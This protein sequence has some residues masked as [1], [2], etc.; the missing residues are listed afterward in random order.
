MTQQ[1][2][3]TP[4][5]L[6]I[7][8][9]KILSSTGYPS[10]G[11]ATEDPWDSVLTALEFRSLSLDVVAGMDAAASP[12]VSNP[13]VTQSLKNLRLTNRGFI[14]I[15]T[16]GSDADFEG[17]THS[18]F[19]A[20]IASL[21]PE[22]GII[23]V[24]EG[25]YVFD[26]TVFLPKDV[27]IIGIHPLSVTIQGTG[28][29]P[30]FDLGENS[31]VELVTV[32]N[33]TAITNPVLNLTGM[34]S[35]IRGSRI[36]SY[37]LLGVKLVG[38]KACV[39][40]CLLD[41]DSSGIWLQGVYQLVE[42]CSFSGTL[43]DGVLRFENSMCSAL[44]NFIRD[45]V[46]GPSYLINSPSN[47]NN[48]LVANHLGTS[49][50]VSAAVDNGTRSVRYANTP[51]M[52]NANSNNFLLSLQLYTG[53]PTLASTEMVL[54]NHVAH[55]T[56]VDKDATAIL[57]S[58]DYYTQKIYERRFWFLTSE[59]P[60]FD[61]LGVPTSGVCSWDGTTLNWPAFALRA[62]TPTNLSWTV[63]ASSA[64]IGIGKALT[65]TIDPTTSGVVVPIVQDLSLVLEN[66]SDVN[67]QVIAFCPASGVLIW[68][69]GYR[70]LT[71]LTSFDIDGIPLPITRY[72]GISTDPRN[73][74]AMP[75]TSFA[76][77][78]DVT[79][80]LSSQS[81][82]LHSLY[83]RSNLFE[84][85]D[86]SINTFPKAGYLLD[87][88]DNLLEEPS[89]LVQVKG[90]TYALFPHYGLYRWYRSSGGGAGV[91][92][93][94]VSNPTGTGPYAAMSLIG[95]SSIAL[96]TCAGAISI[97]NTDSLTWS[98]VTPTTALSLPLPDVRPAGYD[99]AGQ[100]DF[101]FQTPHY[102]LFTLID[103]RSLLYF[104]SLNRLVES[105]RIFT[106]TP[107]G[108]S[109][110]GR[111]LKDSGFNVARNHWID[112]VDNGVGSTLEGLPLFLSESSAI[113]VPPEVFSGSI[114]SIKWDTLTH[115]SFSFDPHSK[116]FLC[117]AT[118]GTKFYILGGGLGSTKL[119]SVVGIGTTLPLPSEEIILSGDEL[120]I[121]ADTEYIIPAITYAPPSGT[122]VEF[123]DFIPHGWLTHVGCQEV[124]VFGT[125]ASTKAF[126]V[127][128]GK[129]LFGSLGSP[130]FS[131]TRMVLGGD[132]SNTGAIGV[133]D[134][135]NNQGNGDIHI[136]ASD[137]ARSNRPTWWTY[138]RATATWSSTT[139]SDVGGDVTL[140][141][142][143]AN[144]FAYDASVDR[145]AGYGV[146]Y[147]FIQFLVRDAS[148]SGRPTMFSYDRSTYY[149]VRLSE[150]AGADKLVANADTTSTS[151]FY[152]GAY[153]NA[154]DAVIWVSRQSSGN[155][156][157]VFFYFVSA[158]LW[159]VMA[160][161]SGG[162]Y[163]S[164]VNLGNPPFIKR[165]GSMIGIPTLTEFVDDIVTKNIYVWTQSAGLLKGE[166]T[167]HHQ[168]G[169][170]GSTWVRYDRRQPSALPLFSSTP[171]STYSPRLATSRCDLSIQIGSL[172]EKT[173]PLFGA[174]LSGIA[175]SGLLWFETGTKVKQV[176]T[177]VWL[178]LNRGGYLWIGNL[179]FSTVQQEL[180][181]N[182]TVIRGDITVTNLGYT[183]NF[184]WAFNRDQSQIAI[185]YKDLANSSKL[186]FILYNI[187]TNSITHERGGLSGYALGSTPKIA[188]NL[189]NNLLTDSWSIV[190]QESAIPLNARLIFFKR[191]AL[192]STWTDEYAL[193][194][195]TG[196]NPDKPIHHT[197]G[198]VLVVTEGASFNAQVNKKDITTGLWSSV[199]ITGGGFKNP[200]FAK[201]LDGL[202]WWIFGGV[203]STAK[204]AWS[205][206]PMSGW[207]IWSG[208]LTLSGIGYTRV[209]TP[210]LL[211][212][213]SSIVVATSA[214]ADGSVP[215]GR[216]LLIWKFSN[217]GAVCL[218]GA[219][220]AKGR[221]Q[222]ASYSG[223][224]EEGI[225]DLSWT[226][227]KK[228]LYGA[229]RPTR[230]TLH[231]SL[232]GSTSLWE[233][234]H[235]DSLLGSGR[236]I[237][238]GGRHF[239]EQW[240]S[241]PYSGFGT[242]NNS[243][244]I[245]YPNL[246]YWSVLPLA[247]RTSETDFT[248]IKWPFTSSSGY[249][250]TTGSLS[251]GL[252]DDADLPT[253]SLITSAS[254]LWP[255][256]MGNTR[257]S[258]LDHT[259]P[260]VFSQ[261][262]MLGL[263]PPSSMTTLA[264]FG[265]ASLGSNNLLKIQALAAITING[266]RTWSVSPTQQYTL[267]GPITFIIDTSLA[268][269]GAHLV[270]EFNTS[271]SLQLDS[272]EAPLSYWTNIEHSNTKYTIVVG[273]VREQG[274]LLYPARGARGSQLLT[275]GH[276]EPIELISEIAS[277]QYSL[278]YRIDNIPA[279][280]LDSATSGT[281][282]FKEL[283]SL[284]GIQPSSLFG[285]TK[286]IA[287]RRLLPNE[288]WFIF[289]TASPVASSS[290]ICGLA[291]LTSSVVTLDKLYGEIP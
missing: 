161:G 190:A 201:S 90:T 267:V 203:D 271:D 219:Y 159:Q 162:T 111:H 198:S 251:T 277:W 54:S 282:S 26:S 156:I 56:T 10:L 98:T 65:I 228:L 196:R 112:T 130:S 183:D 254:R 291:A 165:T 192:S 28:D 86:E 99:T 158:D 214:T 72:I 180:T 96:L 95:T 57:S 89:H 218:L 163:L 103:G 113:E 253:G 19:D 194:V 120:I 184:D 148:R 91:W 216:E 106:E 116:A 157:R 115:E 217:S 124:V 288:G 262:S 269:L 215:A 53:Q 84:Y 224:E 139:L 243:L 74:P 6:D 49:V 52:F 193:S 169:I 114:K 55:D 264:Y 280:S 275:F 129:V 83:E 34:G 4:S 140:S 272:T 93:V 261:G 43:A 244:I 202:K 105:P 270:L 246:N 59:D 170:S 167:A 85:S 64:V 117:V 166:I 204:I 29:F 235:G 110:L 226:S 92:G 31:R 137:A 146:S 100:S 279:Y 188:Y 94:V 233:V 60:T 222:S 142:A 75:T 40:N 174:G 108:T 24:L 125:T 79:E 5:I 239:R 200:K 12:D 70:I 58:L 274:L 119:L 23:E 195:G 30:I 172:A 182:P 127:V 141:Q 13:F 27:S 104:Q 240:G 50:A 128:M 220:T 209:S 150:S 256:I 88:T 37:P 181:P 236:Y 152:G 238:L 232:R 20:A 36:Q 154:W 225:T 237:T 87:L 259:G 18:V 66:P 22:G 136:L 122:T 21:P 46:I 208:S 153:H 278:P 144:S 39:Q 281:I 107:K 160:V 14:L 133:I 186:G 9:S 1:Q 178:G 284:R 187:L 41:S 199:E 175:N 61:I 78:D 126:T 134:W 33:L 138:T 132:N 25:T 221:I 101:V 45:S 260:S 68:T 135:D 15:G 76:I 247:I 102:S 265:T 227:D 7:E 210:V 179:S 249:L 63:V 51:N 231:W 177:S 206:N 80:K 207:S 118:N 285:L 241:A 229:L 230:T 289:Q 268:G 266:T 77:G 245:E 191:L 121:P 11:I 143:V 287:V 250:F 2:I 211:P 16:V 242:A 252:V 189:T 213:N 82:L 81:S 258:G 42:S 290:R 283:G 109:L 38:A 62:L 147:P 205:D 248:S 234:P 286:Q 73:T 168:T 145:M 197:D 97:W 255:R 223:E 123:S 8:D 185:V 176:S 212:L 149:S 69:E 67:T 164:S 273:E 35:A 44:S 32:E 17:S 48:K 276:L 263:F 71:G 151:Q 131:W 171:M 257:W 155:Q 47:T 173:L 3:S